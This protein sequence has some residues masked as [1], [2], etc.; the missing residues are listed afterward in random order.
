MLGGRFFSF[1]SFSAQSFYVS[2][3]MTIGTNSIKNSILFDCERHF[4]FT[5]DSISF[6]KLLVL[7]NMSMKVIN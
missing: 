6:L 4:L 5:C 7:K 3:L 2:L 1:A